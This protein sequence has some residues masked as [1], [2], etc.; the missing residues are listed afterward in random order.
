MESLREITYSTFEVLCVDNG[1]NDGSP[2]MIREEFPEVRLLEQ[3]ENLGFVG[4]NILAYQEASGE[5][6]LFLNSDTQVEPQFLF[7]MTSFMEQNPDAGG[8]E[9]KILWMRDPSRL[10]SV[11]DYLTW[12]G[13][14]YHDR[15][16]ALDKDLEST[17][18]I[19]SAK[20]ACMMFRASVLREVGMFDTKYFAYFEETDLCWRVW[21]SGWKIYFVPAAKV[22]HLMAGTSRD[23]DSHLVNYHSFKNRIH[24]MLKNFGLL[25]LVKVVPIH[26]IMCL[27]IA[28]LYILRGRRRKGAAIISAMI[29]N[30][31]NLTSTVRERRL[32][33]R[34]IRRISDRELMKFAKIQVPLKYFLS[35][36]REY[37]SV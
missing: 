21:L 19:F 30:I 14:L 1:S 26:L 10:D 12:T 34:D 5:Y 16:L 15:Y 20:G 35:L 8:C 4:A 3:Q 9:P 22:S 27:A 36:Y 24:S 23:T 28:V 29:W 6:I 32:V 33:Q 37:D 7:H 25:E 2:M 17:F 11:G 18:P 13:M 31:R